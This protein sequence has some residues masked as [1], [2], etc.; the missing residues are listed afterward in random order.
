MKK[1][2]IGDIPGNA[3][4]QW[5]ELNQGSDSQEES[6]NANREQLNDHKLQSDLEDINILRNRKG[7]K[8]TVY[9]KN[10][11]QT[12]EMGPLPKLHPNNNLDDKKKYRNNKNKS[13]NT[14]ARYRSSQNKTTTK[15]P[16]TSKL[17]EKNQ[18]SKNSVLIKPIVTR[19]DSAVSSNTN[20][21]A[22]PRPKTTLE[23]LKEISADISK[24]RIASAKSR[25]IKDLSGLP[26]IDN[27][28]GGLA[29]LGLDF[30]TAFTKAVIRYQ[31]NHYA[32]D[33][34][35]AVDSEDK[36][37]LPSVFSEHEDG[38][39]VLGTNNAPGWKSVSGIKLK[40]LTSNSP[41]NPNDMIDAVIFLALT[42]RYS[43]YWFAETTNNKGTVLRWNLHVGLPTLSWDSTV[44][45]DLF[46]RI[47]QAAKLLASEGGLIT[48]KSA[49]EALVNWTKI[50]RPFVDVFPEFACQ[51][52]S[53]LQSTERQSDVHGLID[54]G[55]GTVDF[56]FF[57]VHVENYETM[58][59]VFSSD[60]KNLGAHY[61]IAASAGVNGENIEWSDAA[62]SYSVNEYSQI[63]N[64]PT[65]SVVD[66]Q[67]VLL[68][69]IADIFNAVSQ[70]AK[71]SYETSPA[72]RL[73]KPIR[74]FFCGGGSRIEC[75]KERIKD[76]TRDSPQITG[77]YYQLSSLVKP[78]D[79]VGDIGSSFDRLSVA[80][81]LSQPGDNIGTIIRS[82][83][84]EPIRKS[85]R[86]HT[87]HRDDDR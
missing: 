58:I 61:L 54:I 79:L 81:G 77:I 64:E 18:I 87:L 24:L 83:D 51:L 39:C 52:Y 60:V 53:Y 62:A 12:A 7:Q 35:Y 85:E 19:S 14:D 30:G 69:C 11:S 38:R 3:L 2:R 48:R 65:V 37:L 45:T 76:I 67:R 50:E 27:P 70:A 9:K 82:T 44:I 29:I 31:R 5:K 84:L 74:L 6:R 86:T 33:W 71:R 1:I 8:V 17:S 49:S 75:F 26:V 56:A 80:Y 10:K 46:K 63:L 25:H 43:N 78:K 32:V 28:N 34:S 40:I 59:P 20:V 21:L 47:S 23:K 55:A 72:Y 42:F 57:N 41:K 22:K 13:S 68:S 66:R 4:I 15:K 16:T 36:Y 73:G